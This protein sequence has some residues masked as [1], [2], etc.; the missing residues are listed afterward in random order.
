M[1]TPPQRGSK[2]LELATA[3][4]R[5]LAS[6][7]STDASSLEL[8]ERLDDDARA[9]LVSLA[10]PGGAAAAAPAESD[11]SAA[12]RESIRA[13]MLIRAHRVRGHLEANLDPLEL[14]AKAPHADLDPE[15]YGF[16]QADWDRSIF[17]DG[18]LGLDTATLREIMDVLRRD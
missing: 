10:E 2:A 1:Q 17:I 5:H 4:R 18:Q 11:A 13:M 3:Y 12:A 9:W 8:F 6:P 16:G 15:T 7:D 14:A